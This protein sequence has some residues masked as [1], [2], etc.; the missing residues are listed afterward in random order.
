[1][2]IHIA[3]ENYRDKTLMVNNSIYFLQGST[4]LARPENWGG[5]RVLPDV[6]E[7]WQGQ[8]NRIHDRLRFRKRDAAENLGP[9]V[10]GINGW[11]I[12]RLAP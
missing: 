3:S 9:F 2:C 12:D 10:E 6:F 7:F 5:Y 8:S 11:I 4:P 1:M